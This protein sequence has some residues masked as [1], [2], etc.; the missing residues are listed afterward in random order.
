MRV[1]AMSIIH[2]KTQQTIAK[3]AFKKYFVKRLSG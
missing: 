1:T 2:N 3:K